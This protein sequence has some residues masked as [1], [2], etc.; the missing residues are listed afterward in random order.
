MPVH[1][2]RNRR[3]LALF[4][5]AQLFESLPNYESLSGSEFESAGTVLT[6]GCSCLALNTVAHGY[7]LSM[8]VNH[9]EPILKREP[10]EG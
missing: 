6:R 8:P 10:L 3:F 5:M 9:L 4:D 7:A 1:R 2:L